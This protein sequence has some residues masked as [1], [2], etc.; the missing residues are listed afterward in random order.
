MSNI[1]N[2][3]TFYAAVTATLLMLASWTQAHEGHAHLPVTMKKAVGIALEM[4]HHAS[5]EAQAGLDLQRLDDSWAAL[6]VEAARIHENGRGYYI[7]SVANPV[8]N[9]TL[10]V[11]VL[12]DGRVDA[13]N[14][15]GEFN[16][17]V[18]FP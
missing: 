15:S 8:R 17:P 2:R 16:E 1:F 6:P 13:A 9:E 11:R 7:V 3:S 4:A 5:G 14:F 18:E 10:Y 12:L